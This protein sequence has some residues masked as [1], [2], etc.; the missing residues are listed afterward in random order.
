MSN[1]YVTLNPGTSGSKVDTEELTVNSQTVER[2]RIQV[3]GAADVEIGAVKNADQGVGGTAYGS[4][5]R[6][7]GKNPVVLYDAAGVAAVYDSLGHPRVVV[8]PSRDH[9]TYQAQ[10]LAS[11]IL[12]VTANV[13]TDIA[14]LW[15]PSSDALRYE[16]LRIWLVCVALGTGAQ[17]Y[18]LR[19]DFITAL[20][21]TPGG[22]AYTPQ[23]LDRANAAT[24]ATFNTTPSG[25]PTYLANPFA[26]LAAFTGSAVPGG[27]VLYD[28]LMPGTQ[29]IALRG[30]VSEGI[31]VYGLAGGVNLTTGPR[32]IT[33]FQYRA[34]TQ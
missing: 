22:T 16:V 33:L 32:F 20:N 1:A 17:L 28:A 4:V 26:Q 19:A 15:H 30:S 13:Q 24:N 23:P 18:S 27:I 14:Y 29:P 6:L 9:A 10:Q 31:G 7:A 12:T 25:A 8:Q 2:Q 3:A 34:V 21:G 11:T 5:V